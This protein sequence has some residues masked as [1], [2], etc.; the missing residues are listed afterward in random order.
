MLPNNKKNVCHSNSKKI[1]KIPSVV[2]W[3]FAQRGKEFAAY[4]VQD[5]FLPAFG[6]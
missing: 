3:A 5:R 6:N 4:F 2:I 1:L